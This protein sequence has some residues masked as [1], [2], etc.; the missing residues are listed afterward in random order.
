[1][2]K[3]LQWKKLVGKTVR[4]SLCSH[5]CVIK[6][7]ETGFCKVRKNSGG[8]LFSLSYGNARGVSIDPIEKK[9]FFHFRP[10]SQVLSFGTPGCNFTCLGC[11]NW[12]LSQELRLGGFEKNCRQIEPESLVKLAQKTDGLAYT[13][14][15][16]TI[17]WEYALDCIR[18]SKKEKGISGRK[19]Y[20]VFVSNG[21]FSRELREEIIGK[22]L[23][24]AVRIDYKFPDDKNYKSYCAG[25]MKPVLD[26]ISAFA[27][28]K[29]HLEIIVL[30]IPGLN[31]S[32]ASLAKASKAIAK[33]NPE[34]PVHFSR[35][36]PD[37]SFRACP[38]TPER[39]LVLAK[40]IANNAGLKNVYLG[41]AS[42]IPNGEDTFCSGCKKALIRRSG[43][44]VLENLVKGGK[45]P[46]CG[47]S[48]RGFFEKCL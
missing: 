46:S 3:A 47:K 29:V 22:K 18:L 5:Y 32:K 43:F 12:E 17:F 45:C 34:I 7:G 23:L 11:Q 15:E 26:N 41:N 4:C 27:A 40:K 9:P 13:Y 31:D 2:K 6:D 44:F 1:M 20:N 35:F 25:K 14:S 30:V 42:E 28:S 37:G 33:I 39:T 8:T 24:D 36:H 48:V 19:L 21:F 16:P 38:P 10:G